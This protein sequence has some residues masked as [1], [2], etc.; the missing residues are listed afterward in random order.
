M[1]TSSFFFEFEIWR[2]FTEFGSLIVRVQLAGVSCSPS[3]VLISPLYDA[4]V[5]SRFSNCSI[6]L[7]VVE[8]SV[9]KKKELKYS[10]VLVCSMLATQCYPFR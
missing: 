9:D 1:P 2:I 4:R 6:A 5:F 10:R 8:K 3:R 7:S